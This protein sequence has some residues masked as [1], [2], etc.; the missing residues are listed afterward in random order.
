MYQ[1]GDHESI[2]DSVEPFV[3]TFD[4]EPDLTCG[5]CLTATEDDR[6]IACG[7]ILMTSETEGEVWLKLGQKM[8]SLTLCKLLKQGYK[9][10]E[11]SFNL[12]RLTARVQEGWDTGRRFVEWFGFEGTSETI[13]MMGRTYRIYEKWLTP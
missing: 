9:I 10:A 11:D 13:Q 3:E 7:G 5:V 4:T 1:K 12:S 8:P 2:K 6:P